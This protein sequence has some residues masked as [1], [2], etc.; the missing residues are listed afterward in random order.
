MTGRLPASGT[1]EHSAADRAAFGM[2]DPFAV[3]SWTMKVCTIVA[4]NYLAHARV[5]A[6]SFRE[7]HPNGTCTVL[8][9]D[10]LDRTVDA[11]A[12][13]FEVLYVE[14][15]GVPELRVLFPRYSA[16][17]LSAAVRPWFLKR[18]LD[19]GADHVVYLDPD[20]Q[21]FAPLDDIGELVEKHGIV[22]APRV[23]EPVPRDGERPTEQEILAD[24]AYDLGFIA[25]G[26][27]ETAERFLDW[28]TEGLLKVRSK[29]EVQEIPRFDDRWRQETQP[30]PLFAD[31]RW[32][33]LVPNLFPEMKLLRDPG[34][35]VAYW[36]L[37]ARSPERN[38]NRILVNGQRLRYFH[39]SGFLPDRPHWLSE[40]ATRVKL[41]ENKVL[42]DLCISYAARLKEH[43][44]GKA[45]SVPYR[46]GRLPNG[47]P[48]DDITRRLYNEAV[49]AGEDFG[50]IFEP[51]G[52]E[53][54]LGWLNSPAEDGGRHGITRYMRGGIYPVRSDVQE[55]FKDL[56]GPGGKGFIR[57]IMN[58]GRYRHD[59]PELLVPGDPYG[60]SKASEPRM[61]REVDGVNV[62]GYLTG[63]MGLGEV[64]RQNIAALQAV[65]IPVTTKTFNHFGNRNQ[66]EF[67]DLVSPEDYS[68]NL[69]CLQPTELQQFRRDVGEAFFEGR[70]TIGMWG[71]ELDVFPEE[72]FDS[73]G[74]VDEVW[75]WTSYVAETLSRQSS[76]PVVTIPPPV[77]APDLGDAKADIGI[78][79]GFTFL[80]VFDFHSVMQRKNPHGLVEAFKRAFAPGEG[81]QLVLKSINGDVRP[82]SLEQLKVAALDRD[83]IFVVDKYVSAKEKT[84]LMANCDCYVSL[85]RSE[86]FGLTPAEAM[87]VGKPVIATGFSGNTD[88]M[89]SANSY[90][91]DY[92]M[93]EVGPGSP[94]YEA[95]GR[96]A[97]PDLDHAAALMRRV[98]ENPEEAKATGERARRDVEENLSLEVIGKVIR[99]RLEA[100][101]ATLDPPVAPSPA[102]EKAPESP[103]GGKEAPGR[104]D[105]GKLQAA[106]KILKQGPAVEAPSRLGRAG[107]LV[108][109]LVLRGMRPFTF[110]Q[111]QFD[112]ALV[113]ALQET[114]QRV[115]SVGSRVER[116]KASTSNK[117]EQRFLEIEGKLD[118]F[119]A[120]LSTIAEGE[121]LGGVPVRRTSYLG[122][123][124][125]Y[126]YDSLIGEVIESGE[127]WDAILTMIVAELLPEDEPVVCEVGA[128]IGASLLQILRVR[129]RASVVALEPSTRFLP[130]LERNLEAV[131][132]GHVEVLPLL[133]GREAGSMELY[134]NASTASVVSADYDGHK[135]RGKHSAEMT[136]LDEIFR[137]RSKVDFIKI[138]TNGF[139]FEVLRGAEATLKRDRPAL[140]FEVAT[141]LLSEPVADLAWLQSL[142]YQRFV[143]VKPQGKLHGRILIHGITE[144]PDQVVTW[145][146]ETGLCDV[147]ACPE[148]SP[149]EARLERIKFV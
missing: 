53:K 111:E 13:P 76:K 54:F 3:Y 1:R 8:L 93:V 7:Q 41:S 78:P 14:N 29:E 38:G 103:K 67:E 99:T 84:A 109:R 94:P 148:G 24:G 35:D 59:I 82:G 48:H 128:N 65:G 113:G 114:A 19:Q 88:F 100:P 64:A 81:P 51:E 130:F 18:L 32:V 90:L 110:Y 117:L 25:L 74:L 124:F 50:D 47:L 28:W 96:W 138:D 60:F 39:F 22:L 97:E 37:H 122:R 49:D 89:N 9:L 27:G 120:R 5:L 77:V 106:Q 131:G 83:D 61:K 62:V 129:P 136:T 40:H 104:V 68:T 42:A 52:A 4:R 92:T 15:L 46:Y 31:R 126:P 71:W 33:D 125:E 137:D 80:F 115:K 56:S 63:E 133:A 146:R 116:L 108:R 139:D 6:E 132:F 30:E 70:R 66:H 123:P 135:P 119:D 107:G 149:Y 69:I 144:D 75:V 95:H 91:V 102:G 43:G 16:V 45:S 2:P 98:W 143:C 20:I 26:S 44:H 17:E 10:D 79:E 147:L 112:T 145:S 127:E 36:N 134:N 21:L 118:S 101:A 23:T 72:W 140:Y 73:L 11:G 121:K 57:W 87:A 141:H 142:G 86:G 34:C 85:H 105:G 12:E 58:H 55:R